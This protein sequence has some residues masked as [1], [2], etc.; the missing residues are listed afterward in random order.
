MRTYYWKCVSSHH[1]SICTINHNPRKLRDKLNAI[2]MFINGNIKSALQAKKA[3]RT[4]FEMSIQPCFSRYILE[5]NKRTGCTFNI[6]ILH[7]NI[8]YCN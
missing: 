5:N 6:K 7:Y 8:L 1:P 2:N 4:F 3:N